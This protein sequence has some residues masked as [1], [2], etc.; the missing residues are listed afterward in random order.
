LLT[1]PSAFCHN[2]VAQ[3]AQ[4]TTIKQL[5][6]RLQI[7]IAFLTKLEI[8]M[9]LSTMQKVQK[10]FTLIELMIVVAIIGIL[11]AVALPAYQDYIARAQTA[12]GLAD[13]TP[14]KINAEDKL[15]S[16]I[17][18][19]ITSVASL[20]IQGATSRCAIT[21][22]IKTDGESGILCTFNA[23]SASAVRDK[24]IMWYRAADVTTAGSTSQG[25]WACQSNLDAKHTPRNCSSLTAIPTLPT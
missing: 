15:N 3:A 11:A 4:K 18:A 19:A 25:Q 2:F 24:G 12:V 23:G 22:N 6:H 13:I 17:V 7:Y 8:F 9:K 1:P 14:A 10:G 16:G 20:G 5:A 21:T